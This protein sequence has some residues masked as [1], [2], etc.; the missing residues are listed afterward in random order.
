MAEWRNRIVG[1]A[2]V[3]LS[4]LHANPRNWRKHPKRQEETLS[5]VIS[6]VGVVQNIV[7][8]KHTGLVVDGHLRL[9]LAAKQ[10]QSVVPV[11]YIDISDEEE[12][13]I[14][15]SF[16]PI[17]ALAETDATMLNQLLA[18]MPQPSTTLDA[19]LSSV[20]ESQ[21][22]VLQS[23]TLPAASLD[24]LKE[25][26]RYE[27][28]QER[29]KVDKSKNLLGDPLTK[30][31]SDADKERKELDSLYGDEEDDNEPAAP[32]RKEYGYK[33]KSGE[34]WCLGNAHLIHVSDKIV[35]INDR[36]MINPQWTPDE[37]V[38]NIAKFFEILDK[39]FAEW[40]RHAEEVGVGGLTSFIMATHHTSRGT[41]Y[42]LVLRPDQADALFY[43]ADN[44]DYFFFC[45]NG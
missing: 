29:Q 32:K 18:S 37:P 26:I 10:K 16:D 4:E 9:A 2:D 42:Q 40:N 22:A 24:I 1:Y 28:E 20:L 27:D 23:V 17:G 12:A 11:T 30:T 5:D 41:C 3:A 8:N 25:P 38:R 19:M 44:A 45:V 35:N 36:T 33:P 43:V 15:A 31:Y 39:G 6:T 34:T 13:M 14:M 21:H 7:V